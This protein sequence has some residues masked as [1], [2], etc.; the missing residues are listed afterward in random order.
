MLG[1]NLAMLP[2]ACG[3]G[4]IGISAL[5]FA[6]PMRLDHWIAAVVQMVSMSLVYCV[7][8]NFLSILAPTAIAFGSLRPVR[9]KGMAMVI[10]LVFFLFLMPIALGLTLIPLGIEYLAPGLPFYLILTLI[11]FAG[12]AYFYSNLLGVQGRILQ[13]REQQVLETVAAK[14][15]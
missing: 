5:Q 8:N 14:M 3:F 11:E 12:I 15:E 4:L 9:P 13:S 1:K 2:F 6:Y 10:H 7:L